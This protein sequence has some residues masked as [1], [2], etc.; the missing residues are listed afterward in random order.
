MRHSDSTPAAPGARVS[1][2]ARE[3]GLLSVWGLGKVY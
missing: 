1:H 3:V 2:P